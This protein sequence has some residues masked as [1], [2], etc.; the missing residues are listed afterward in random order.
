MTR[1]YSNNYIFMG[2]ACL[3]VI[4]DFFPAVAW[5]ETMDCFIEG[6]GPIVIRYD[7]RMQTIETGVKGMF[8]PAENVVIT[9][10]KIGYMERS[11]EM[12]SAALIDRTSMTGRLVYWKNFK[13]SPDLT[14]QCIEVR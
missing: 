13:R 9:D 1:D 7:Q 3:S 11:D 14:M 5:S 12:T 4:I 2:I 10:A 8:S 6:N